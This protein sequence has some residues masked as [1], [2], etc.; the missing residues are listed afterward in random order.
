MENEVSG[1]AKL[2]IVLI[3]LAVL[4]G[5]G[6]GIF[7]ISKGTANTGV[8][9]VQ[10][11]LDGVASSTFTSYDQTTIT[12]TMASSAIGDF[13]GENTAIL[14]STKAW[15][16]ILAKQG[17][18]AS[19]T[20]VAEHAA[21]KIEAAVNS[22]SGMVAVYGDVSNVPVVPAY[23]EDPGAA[24]GAAKCYTTTN[25]EGK[26]TQQCFINY[27]AL[28]GAKTD[29]VGTSEIKYGTD[30]EMAYIYFDN[31][32]FRVA[33]GFLTDQSGRVLFNNITGNV[34]RSG[35]TEYIPSS[36]KF[37]CFLIKDSSDTV[38]GISMQQL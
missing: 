38:L 18:A 34:G 15:V 3:A 21:A 28:L 27:N 24:S 5:L 1:I 12:G 4:I 8:N 16:N 13:E 31:N 2:G 7:Q 9:N 19:S 10:S 23:A 26:Y 36:G 35:R 17:S 37:D 14:V 25:S 32:C 33:S 29:E 6:F 22:A 11:E 30:Y 20:A